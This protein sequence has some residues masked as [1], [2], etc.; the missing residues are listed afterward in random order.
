MKMKIN[1]NELKIKRKKKEIL[2]A[3]NKLR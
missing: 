2:A 1:A 3:K